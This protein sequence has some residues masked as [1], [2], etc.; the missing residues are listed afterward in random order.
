[1]VLVC[2]GGRCSLAD[3]PGVPPPAVPWD[4][5]TASKALTN[6]SSVAIALEIDVIPKED[7]KKKSIL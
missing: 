4:N 6:F 2:S 7:M 5:L 1:M 3:E